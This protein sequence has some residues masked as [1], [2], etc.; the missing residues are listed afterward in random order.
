MVRV[1][2]TW[3]YI[4]DRM[5]ARRRKARQLTSRANAARDKG[6]RADA[7]ELYEAALALCPSVAI[8][9]QCGHMLK[10]LRQ[11][12]RAEA[13]YL[14]ARGHRP[15]DVDLNLQL[16]HFFKLNSKWPEAIA[17]YER[18]VELGL[19]TPTELRFSRRRHA[20]QVVETTLLK[21]FDG[22]QYM[23]LNP[24]VRAAGIKPVDHFLRYGAKEGRAV[25]HGSI[26]AELTT[27]LWDKGVYAR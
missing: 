12:D 15:D 8:H 26:R 24:E 22:D 20:M 23:A 7:A 6:D 9:I 25:H 1:M 14:I 11:M 2:G 4:L 18:A 19:P 13:H 16:G 27:N 3:T 5:L 10:E 21:T 17:F